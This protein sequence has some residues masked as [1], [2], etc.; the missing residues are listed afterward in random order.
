[1]ASRI[2]PSRPGK[3]ASPTHRF[4]ALRKATADTPTGAFIALSGRLTFSCKQQP[5]EVHI[6]GLVPD[7]PL[8][9]ALSA[10]IR[11]LQRSTPGTA[12]AGVDVELDL[13]TRENGSGVTWHLAT[14]ETTRTHRIRLTVYPWRQ[15]G[16]SPVPEHRPP[17]PPRPEAPAR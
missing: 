7:I 3:V 1:M 10:L 16:R 6:G 15:P 17:T 2:L 5:V 14:A 13:V 9:N 12:D 8:T 4:V 11:D